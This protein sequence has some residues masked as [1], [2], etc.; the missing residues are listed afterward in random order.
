[1]IPFAP[2]APMKMSQWLDV[3]GVRNCSA[4]TFIDAQ[5]L[6]SAQTTAA[7][8]NTLYG[9]VAIDLPRIGTYHV[10]GGIGS[11]AITLVDVLIVQGG[12]I[13]YRQM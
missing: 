7:H 11:L 8:A 5:F 10:R 2:L 4:R 12:A 9:A 13:H 1:M 6:I 3:L